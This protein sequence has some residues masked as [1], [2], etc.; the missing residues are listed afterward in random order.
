MATSRT[1]LD[2]NVTADWASLTRVSTDEQFQ[3][4]ESYENQIKLNQE[5]AS[6]NGGK[7]YKE[8]KEEG[9]S[10]FKKRV[11]QRPIMM[12]LLQDI[13]AG[14]VKNI[15]AFKRD[16][17]CRDPEDYYY[18]RR[19]FSK[20]GVKV[21]LTCGTEKWGEEA[22]NSPTDELLDGLMPL[23]AKFESM[24]TSQRVKANVQEAVKRG[25]WRSGRPP[26]G[27]TY[28]SETR[29]VEKVS[30][31]AEVCKMIRDLYVKG[32]GSGKIA[33]MLNNEYKIPYESPAANWNKNHTKQKRNYWYEGVVTSIVAKPVYMGVQVWGGEWYECSAIDPIFT[34]EEWEEANAVYQNK[35]NKATPHK[36]F[37]SIF[38]Y[39]DVLYCSYCGN[40]M[41][42][43]Y[44][45]Q[46][47]TRDDGT[48]AKYEY[49]AY[50]C[51]GRWEKHNGCNCRKHNRNHVESAINTIISDSIKGFDIESLHKDLL[52]QISR[53]TKEYTITIEQMQ[54]ELRRIQKL[55]D[56]N[57]EAYMGAKPGSAIQRQ[58]EQ[59]AEQLQSQFEENE[60]KLKM[61]LANPP[62]HQIDQQRLATV[63]EGMKKW[64][65]IMDNPLLGREVKRKLVLD[66]MKRIDLDNEGNMRIEFKIAK[67]F[68]Q[69]SATS[70]ITTAV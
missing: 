55:L 43:T 49:Y 32:Y 47:Y 14:K 63:Y 40:R 69:S 60:A 24:T 16:R 9:V 30:H 29:K 2:Q 64:D 28:S 36:Y 58:L 26:Y 67:N 61:L 68:P 59:K 21:H 46:R 53:Q 23:L 33:D 38:L 37:N 5:T 45:T 20:A 15:V 22:T 12:E 17:I 50:K 66:I 70:C 3:E 52:K 18:L 6:K 1:N 10:A 7:I 35:L 27:Y 51:E 11:Q 48:I 39:K 56:Q 8:Y 42:P 57:I 31:Q 34:K 54:T 4:G 19:M 13:L 44:K 62:D 65:G 41:I 25:E